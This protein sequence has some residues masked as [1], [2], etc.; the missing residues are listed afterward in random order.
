MKSLIINELYIFSPNDK[1]AKVVTFKAGINIVTSSKQDGNKK[2]KSIVLKSIFH[3][4]GADCY[5]DDKWEDSSKVYIMKFS[6]DGNLYTI[7]RHG[8]LFKLLNSENELIFKTI[9]RKELAAQLDLIFNFSVRLPNRN[10]EVLEITSPVYNYIL[11]YIDQDKMD[12]TRFNSFRSLGEYKG[13]KANTLYYHFGVFDERYY[14]IVRQIEASEK[15]QSKK[16]LEQGVVNSVIDRIADTI[17]D[18]IPPA[19]LEILERDLRINTEEYNSIVNRLREIRKKLIKFRNEHLDITSMLSNLKNVSTALNSEIKKLN[20]HKCPY[21]SADIEDTTEYRIIKSND[22]EDIQLLSMDLQ[23]QLLDLEQKIL[24]E[25]KEYSIVSSK[26]KDYEM[27]I[28][29]E[30]GEISDVLRAKN[31]R[32]LLDKFKIEYG[33]ISKQLDDI[34]KKL[35]DLRKEKRKYDQ[36]KKLVNKR[37]SEL[38]Q[39]DRFSFGLQEIDVDRFASIDISFEAGGSNKPIATVIWYFNLLR[40]K[41]EF[42]PNSIK[43]PLVLD[44][45]NNVELDDGKRQELFEYLFENV[46]ANTQLIVSTLGFSKDDYLDAEISNIVE[47]KNPKYSLLNSEDYEQNLDVLVLCDEL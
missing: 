24:S 42:N 11:N 41:N 32:D 10:N 46:D 17:G 30:S 8:R 18:D 43:F 37:Y 35:D 15:E 39:A 14:E 21:C 16:L 23:A 25:E 33:E 6:Y 36:K 40:L 9:D 29:A 2:G 20:A 7:C 47:L 34:I 38:M 3:S 44:S 28:N 27:K 5:F 19:D 45:P 12:C 4:L 1:K 22:S 31:L 13:Y 26:L